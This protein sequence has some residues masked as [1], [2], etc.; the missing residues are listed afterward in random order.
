MIYNCPTPLA[1]LQTQKITNFSWLPFAPKLLKD[2]GDQYHQAT[3]DD[4]EIKVGYPG[5]KETVNDKSLCDKR[6]NKHGRPFDP[7]NV[8]SHHE[9][10]EN[11]AVKQ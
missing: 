1:L 2:Q 11:S 9:Q 8:K 5:E 10:P 3:A 4:V 6:R 7:R